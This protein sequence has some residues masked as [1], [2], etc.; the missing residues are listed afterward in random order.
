M[1]NLKP[2]VALHQDGDV[3][4]SFRELVGYKRYVERLGKTWKRLEPDVDE[5]WRMDG[6][7]D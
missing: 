2:K 5:V 6:L 1:K 7:L 3:E 4:F